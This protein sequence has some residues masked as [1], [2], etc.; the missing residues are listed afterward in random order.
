MG[1]TP[2]AIKKQ[3]SATRADIEDAVARLQPSAESAASDASKNVAL[4]IGDL[5]NK[6]GDVAAQLN[7]GGPKLADPT[8]LLIASAVVGFAA[9][10]FAPSTDFERRRLGPVGAELL[11]RLKS[12]REELLGQGKAVVT[13]TLS[14]A[15]TSAS[16]HGKEAADHLGI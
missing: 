8:P 6:A 4:A 11:S 9:G 2:D 5:G 14:A 3:M 16:K 12:A 7:I 15:K 10:F 13:D 1:Q